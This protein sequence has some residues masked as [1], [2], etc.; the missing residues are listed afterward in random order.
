MSLQPCFVFFVPP[1]LLHEGDVPHT[2]FVGALMLKIPFS[3]LVSSSL[4]EAPRTS[5]LFSGPIGLGS[6]EL[7]QHVGL[8]S[9]DFLNP[10]YPQSPSAR[11]YF[12]RSFSLS[13]RV[14]PP[15]LWSMFWQ[16][17]IWRLWE[18]RGFFLFPL[19][20]R[21][22]SPFSIIDCHG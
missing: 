9:S 8:R 15:L 16:F 18:T 21:W 11:S 6:N 20:F 1:L 12:F 13:H 7:P 2:P 4:P 22:K 10:G 5:P 17:P 3:S 19:F 14:E